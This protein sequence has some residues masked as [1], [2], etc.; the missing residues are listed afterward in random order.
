MK[1]PADMTLEELIALKSNLEEI[2]AEAQSE[3][4]NC[5]KHYD[6]V[7]NRLALKI[8]FPQRGAGEWRQDWIEDRVSKGR[9]RDIPDR[10][11]TPPAPPKH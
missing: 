8:G 5:V 11:V 3:M 9:I 1:H 6:D 7:C 2:A 4:E 10:P